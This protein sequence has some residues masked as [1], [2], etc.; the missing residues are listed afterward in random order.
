MASESIVGFSTGIVDIPH[1]N[2]NENAR[3]F[4]GRYLDSFIQ[5]CTSESVWI[6]GIE[7]EHHDIM[8]MLI[9]IFHELK[10]SLPIP[11]FN[12]AIIGGRDDEGR[13]W[14]DENP[15]NEISMG[16]KCSNSFHCVIVKNSNLQII[17]ARNNPLLSGNEFGITNRRIRDLNS[18]D[19]GLVQSGKEEAKKYLS[20]VVINCDIPGVK[21]G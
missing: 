5:T 8:D 3:N 19:C 9:E 15:S 2:M 14:V 12:S 4:E 7:C 6:S 13:S 1:L 18:F 11:D 17:R 20:R 10:F 16:F 21:C